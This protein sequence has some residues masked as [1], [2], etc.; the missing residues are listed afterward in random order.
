MNVIVLA[1]DGSETPKLVGLT[2][3]LL[4]HFPDAMLH[5]VYV[6]RPVRLAHSSHE[7]EQ[8]YVH[9][10]GR[11]ARTHYFPQHKDRIEL[12]HRIGE[13]WEEICQFARGVSADLVVVGSHRIGVVEYLWPG[14]VSSAIVRHCDK[15]VLVVKEDSR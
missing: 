11:I 15:P 12:H 2:A 1:M 10:L 8:G 5:A 7:N 6:S 4:E 9:E 3:A 13:P 14:S